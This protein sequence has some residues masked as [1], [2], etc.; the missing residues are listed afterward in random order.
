MK[1]G[2]RCKECKTYMESPLPS[3]VVCSP[4]CA[5]QY[6]K[7]QGEKKRKEKIKELKESVKTK[8]DY[9]KEVQVVFNQY[10]RLR[11]EN[12]P[13]ISCGKPLIGK[14]DAGHFYSV[15]SSP[16]LRFNENN[17]FGQCVHCNQHLHGNLHMYRNGIQYRI[18]DLELMELTMEAHKPKHYSIPELI[19][20]KAYYKQKIKDL[21][22]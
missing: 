1:K 12:K 13:C 5:Y 11:D 2:R 4:Q 8:S 21:Q 20:L 22:K 17:T 16:S 19:E 6:S 10:I 9:L 18:T 14:Y 15:G 7:R 3:Q